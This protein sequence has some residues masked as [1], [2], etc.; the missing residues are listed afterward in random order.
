MK[1]ILLNSS[2][3]LLEAALPTPILSTEDFNFVFGGVQNSLPFDR[4]QLVR[5][6]EA[7]ALPGALFTV[8]KDLGNNIC[9]VTTE[10]YPEKK[11]L[12]FIDKRFTVP[13]RKM[14]FPVKSCPSVETVQRSLLRMLGSRYI[15]GGNFHRGIPEML[16]FYPP[17]KE[18]SPLEKSQWIFQGVDCSGL[19]YEATEGYTPRNASWLGDWGC[20]PINEEKEISKKIRPLDA[21]V[22]RLKEGGFHVFF[23]LDSQ[24]VI[25]SRGGKGVF[26]G[27]FHER[28][29]GLLPSRKLVGCWDRSVNS[30]TVRRWHP[31]MV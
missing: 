9:C 4:Q 14:T 20:S 7:I 28:L 25:E 13:Y 5:E 27:D 6:I 31:E 10:A 11:T 26:L 12:L 17:V 29:A 1:T 2:Q 15:W 3:M 16:A 19:I 8:I 21:F 18:L 22:Y 23:Y 30:F 24:T